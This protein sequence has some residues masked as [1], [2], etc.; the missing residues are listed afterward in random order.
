VSTFGK[1]RLNP[2][3]RIE[4]LLPG[5]WAAANDENAGRMVWIA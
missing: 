3:E 2:T 1:L 4:R 5:F